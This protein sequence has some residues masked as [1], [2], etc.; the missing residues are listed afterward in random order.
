MDLASN[1]TSSSLLALQTAQLCMPLYIQRKDRVKENRM[2][3]GK[4]DTSS[5]FF[6]ETKL[7]LLMA[8]GEARRWP[9]WCWLPDLHL[10]SL[11]P[12]MLR[13]NIGGGAN[14]KGQK[15]NEAPQLR[16]LVLLIPFHWKSMRSY[17]WQDQTPIAKS[18]NAHS[19]VQTNQQHRADVWQ[20][21]ES[22]E[23]ALLAAPPVWVRVLK[24]A[25]NVQQRFKLF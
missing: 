4:M 15:A 5:H 2:A 8:L 1:I 16:E 24:T 11:P 21:L 13:G 6:T 19:A 18:T 7:H 25:Y 22:T 23:V 9:V 17:C 3:K 14:K 10:V 20:Q 12:W